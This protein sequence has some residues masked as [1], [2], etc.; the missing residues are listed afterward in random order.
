MREAE[1][2]TGGNGIIGSIGLP[3][4]IEF[5]AALIAQIGFM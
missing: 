2:L 5:L 3:C 4:I 1:C